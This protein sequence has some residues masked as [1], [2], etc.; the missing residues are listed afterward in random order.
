MA[1]FQSGGSTQ[2]PKRRPDSGSSLSIVGVDLEIMGHLDTRGVVK[3][4]GRV[5]GNVTAMEQV[6]VATGATVEGDIVTRE[7]VIGGVVLGGI[8]AAERVELLDTAVVTGNIV[9]ARLL[10]HEGGRINGE[11][12]MRHPG[13]SQ[14]EGHGAVRQ[15]AAEAQVG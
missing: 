7:A 14:D 2:N 3:V 13:G 5:I 10:I 11:V 12:M 6:L 15:V 9:T 1:I 4:E 8:E